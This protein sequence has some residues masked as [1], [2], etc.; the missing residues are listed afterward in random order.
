MSSNIVKF[1]IF[2]IK[3]WIFIGV[4][5]VLNIIKIWICMENVVGEYRLLVV[6]FFF[7]GLMGG[8]IVF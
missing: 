8:F 7:K 6:D 3:E 2:G 1:E 5:I 4:W